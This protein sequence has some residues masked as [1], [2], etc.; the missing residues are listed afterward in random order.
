[1][2]SILAQIVKR[3]QTT[4]TAVSV[5]DGI[6][7]LCVEPFGRQKANDSCRDVY[8]T[9]MTGLRGTPMPFYT[10]SLEPE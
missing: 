4:L 5:L 2:Q 3:A 1:M 9:L 7:L 10:D 8:R 6:Y